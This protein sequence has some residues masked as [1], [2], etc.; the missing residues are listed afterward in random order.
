MVTRPPL[1]HTKNTPVRPSIYHCLK[2]PLRLTA[3]LDVL[4][5]LLLHSFFR[6]YLNSSKFQESMH[7]WPLRLA[8]TEEIGVS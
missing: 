1:E 8:V 2:N 5:F 7:R 3:Y 6:H 4:P